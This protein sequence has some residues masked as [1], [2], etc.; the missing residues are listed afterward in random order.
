MQKN[1][2]SVRFPAKL[3]SAL[4]AASAM[5]MLTTAPVAAQNI[6]LSYDL[7]IGAASSPDFEGARKS[8]SRPWLIL[9]NFKM[10]VGGTGGAGPKQ[11]LSLGPSFA[12]IGKRDTKNPDSHIYGLDRIS[13]GVEAGLRISYRTGPVEAYA[14]ARQGLGGHRGVA[15]EY[16]VS[17]F[18]RPND[19]WTLTSALE[20][21][22][23]NRKYMQAYF[24]VSDDEAAASK[25]H[26]TPYDASRG[27]KAVAVSLEARYALNDDW[28]LFGRAEVKRLRGNAQRSPVT[29]RRN[30]YWA[31][32]GITRHFDIR[33]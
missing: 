24:G 19:R 4:I 29:E 32:V 33:Y 21:Q 10:D 18:A 25:G 8:K 23:G 20:A 13:R 6:S 1:Q 17:A 22:Y 5:T 3:T 27:V 11:G 30:Q 7:G 12:L 2:S 28:A 9:R 26:L 14:T 31:G 16:G 15:G